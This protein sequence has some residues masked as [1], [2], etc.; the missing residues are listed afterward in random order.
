MIY[1]ILAIMLVTLVA[2][3]PKRLVESTKMKVLTFDPIKIID[4]HSTKGRTGPCEPSISINPNDPSIVIAGSVLDNLYVSKDG[5]LTYTTQKL[6]SSFGVYGDPVVRHAYDGSVTYA[7]LSNPSGQAYS[8]DDFLD[9]IVVQ[10]S[11]DMGQTWTNGSSPEADKKKDHDKHWLVPHPNKADV[12]MIWTEFDKYGS[13]SPED[14]SRILFSKSADA[15]LTWSKAIDIS[16]LEGDCLDDDMTTEGAVGAFGLN[17]DYY[18]VWG[19]NQNIYFNK[20][21]DKGMS[22][23]ND[24]ISIANQK[25]GW[26]Y[27]IPGIDRANGMPTIKVDHSNGKYRGRMYVSWGDQSKGTDDTDLWVM[28]SDD[29]GKRWSKPLRVN[30]DYGRPA[31]QFFAAMDLDVV[32]GYLYFIFYDRRNHK[33]DNTDVYLAYSTDGGDRF[34]NMKISEIPFKPQDDLEVFFGDYNDL[35]VYNGIIRPIWT[36]Q[37]GKTLTVQSAVI[38]VKK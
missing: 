31:H 27:M 24:E 9:R 36:R 1:R 23:L 29:G 12:I 7:H 8:S 22:W 4:I 32:T 25:G 19:F 17:D 10:R 35:S 20:S 15:G 3:T 30:D 38:N 26:S 18:V 14:K 6:K 33:D 5:G 13:K 16:S 21:T 11:T 34:V 2:C 37:D 28:Y